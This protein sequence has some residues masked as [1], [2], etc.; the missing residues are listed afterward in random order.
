VLSYYWELPKRGFTGFA[1]KLLNGWALSG[2]TTIQT[3]FPIRITS[4]ADNELMY[5]FDFELPGEPD[6]LA[7]LKKLHPQSNGNYFFDP[8]SF[9]ED[10]G[11][12]PSL[13]GR[14]GSAPRT[15]CCGPHISNTDFAILKTLPLSESRRMEFRAELFNIFNHTQFYNPDGDSSDGAQFGQVTQVRDPRLV[16]FALKLFF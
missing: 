14:I 8:T 9:T 12:D 7:P 6:Q 2:I 11:V 5:S 10:T 16:Q 15:I 4:Q 1:D 13:F 3:G